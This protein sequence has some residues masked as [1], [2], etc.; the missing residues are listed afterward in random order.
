MKFSLQSY[1][2]LYNTPTVNASRDIVK[3]EENLIYIFSRDTDLIEIWSEASL[4]LPH[5]LSQREDNSVK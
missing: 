1:I 5:L 3:Q 4:G 2:T